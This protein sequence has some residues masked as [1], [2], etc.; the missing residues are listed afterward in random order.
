MPTIEKADRRDERHR[1]AREGKFQGV[2]YRTGRAG[3]GLAAFETLRKTKIGGK[4]VKRR[5]ARK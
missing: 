3:E 1:K 2:R 4:P 5:K